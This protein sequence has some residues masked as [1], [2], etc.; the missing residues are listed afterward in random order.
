MN[1]QQE[2]KPEQAEPAAPDPVDAAGMDSFPASD[3]PSWIPLHSGSPSTATTQGVSQ[4]PAC[5]SAGPPADV[6]ASHGP[7]KK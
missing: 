2:R 4:E 5:D 3:P 1:R 7:G 6:M